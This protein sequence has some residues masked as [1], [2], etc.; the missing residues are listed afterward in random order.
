MRPLIARRYDRFTA[1]MERAWLD[2]ARAALVGDAH[3]TVVEIGA[4]TGKNL[5]HYPD[6]V[7]RLVLTEPTATMRDQLRSRVATTDPPF[8][9]DI[10]DANADR[11]PL[12]DESADIVVSTLVLCSVPALEVAVAELRRVLRP[13]GELRMI[14][15]VAS[16][17]RRERRWQ[18]RLDRPWHWLE[19]SCHLCHDTL[20]ALADAGFRLDELERSTPKGMPPLLRDVVQG[21]TTR[22]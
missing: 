21:R 4:G 1:A 6:T 11:I 8:G 22:A 3:G 5:P 17:R 20:A 7:E 19:G 12:P 9:V 15:H 14:E 13:E 16:Q 2:D 18:E 10:V